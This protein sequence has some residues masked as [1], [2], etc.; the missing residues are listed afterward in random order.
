METHTV[1]L[2]DRHPRIGNFFLAWL[3]LFILAILLCNQKL[4]YD[5]EY[6]WSVASDSFSP[7]WPFVRL[8]SMLYPFR[9]YFYPFLI[10]TIRG[11]CLLP[12]IGQWRAFLLFNSALWAV[13][14]TWTLPTL[15]RVDTASKRVRIGIP[16]FCCLIALFW[17][18]QLAKPLS[19]TPAM[20]FFMTAVALF[21]KLRDAGAATLG[22]KIRCLLW[23]LA[24]GMLL[25]AAYNTRTAY[26]YAVIPAVV[27]FV[28]ILLR[29]I[30]GRDKR[31]EIKLSLCCLLSFVL[32]LLLFALP[33][34]KIS[35][36]ATGVPSPLIN[37]GLFSELVGS[38]A[39]D[40]ETAQLYDGLR[41]S[42]Y[43]SAVPSEDYPHMGFIINN[44][45]G[46]QIH[47]AEELTVDSFSIRD[48]IRLFCKYPLEIASI[49]AT[50]L[51]SYV[52]PLWRQNLITN[53]FEDK[54]NI[55]LCNAMLWLAGIG[56]WFCTKNTTW[57]QY[58]KDNWPLM[59]CLFPCLCMLPAVPEIRFFLPAY[60]VLYAYLCYKLD[61]GAFYEK[62]RAHKITACLIAFCLLA[63]WTCAICA[64]LANIGS[65]AYTSMRLGA[66]GKRALSRMTDILGYFC[67]LA[68]ALLLMRYTYETHIGKKDTAPSSRKLLL[69]CIYG[70]VALSGLF[71]LYWLAPRWEETKQNIK[72]FLPL[73]MVYDEKEELLYEQDIFVSQSAEAN[74][75]LQAEI[76]IKPNGLY[77]VEAKI[78]LTS[79]ETVPELLYI[80]LYGGP[81]YDNAAQDIRIINPR[82]PL[83]AVIDAGDAPERVALRVVSIND[84]PYII[85]ELR[86]TEVAEK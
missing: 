66:V 34:M 86:L 75:Q 13:F 69:C 9:G 50:H 8:S 19:D 36:K 47:E 21:I 28:M 78:E 2:T 45:T 56:G 25:Y 43:E 59:L 15:F 26:L 52:T 23:S 54:Y 80:D 68:T 32:G 58:C 71:I 44:M 74:A 29:K 67:V 48:L 11:T 63:V 51:I 60:C 33:Q 72:G 81:D 70:S 42:R 38:E 65:P 53:V 7:V 17:D 46:R 49:Y 41:T 73:E 55:F 1:Q 85:R 35:E 40:L 16:V 30:A 37:T 83:K 39:K 82:L 3:C 61:Y 27:V 79:K 64:I 76:P 18:A 62:L 24:S 6:Y 10:G 57:R 77:K 4:F 14:A 31:G 84:A 12:D 20:V 5:M 22:E